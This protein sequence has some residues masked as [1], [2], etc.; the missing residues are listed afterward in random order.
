MM[1]LENKKIE[2]KEMQIDHL[3]EKINHLLEEKLS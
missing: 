1:N 3:P 2:N